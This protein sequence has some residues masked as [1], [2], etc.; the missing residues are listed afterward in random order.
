MNMIFPIKDNNIIKP[1]IEYNGEMKFL[2]TEMD[3]YGYEFDRFELTPPVTVYKNGVEITT[4][5]GVKYA[6][7]TK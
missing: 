6:W 5:Q 2:S 4:N 7:R 1:K 3:A